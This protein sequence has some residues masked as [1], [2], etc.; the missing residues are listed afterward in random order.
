[1]ARPIWSGAINFGLVSVPVAL[2]SATRDHTVHF[3]QLER[4]TSDRVR[5]QRV[6]E[7]TGKEVAYEDIVKGREVGGGEYVV[8]EP[9]ELEAVAPGRSR[10][11]DISTFVDLDDID[12]IYFQK[13]YWLAPAK[14][15]DPKAYALLVQ[16]MAKRNRVGIGNFVMR[17]KEYLAAIRA[18][19]GV[20]ALDT[21]FFADEILDPS[22]QLPET[23]DQRKAQGKELDMAVTL[24]DS[25]SGEWNPED[26][27]DTYTE[28]VEQLVKDK[29]A[30]REVVTEPEP[31]EPTEVTDLADVLRQS[32]EQAKSSRR[33][34]RQQGGRK[35]AAGKQAAGKQA[36]GG[37]KRQGPDLSDVSK[38]ELNDMA[39]DLGV[40]GRSKMSRSQ[41]EK[42]VTEAGASA[43]ATKKAS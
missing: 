19:D 1:M 34:S 11:L 42:A 9:K 30:G 35:K 29:R 39:R 10:T 20:L 33:S 24:V 31:A 38:S 21:M 3:R 25:M 6:N 12:P 22:E 16:A 2:Y 5:Y 32:V 18:D 17:G 23:P 4:G 43:P 14:G 28:R 26:Y 13:T 8:V 36:S 27:R 7:R 37:R 15:G 41:L 40:Q